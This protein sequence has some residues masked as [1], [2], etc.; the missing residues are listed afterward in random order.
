[1]IKYMNILLIWVNVKHNSDFFNMIWMM[2][3][4]LP[5]RKVI[6]IHGG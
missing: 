2:S 3:A 6:Y 4:G 1:M 5:V